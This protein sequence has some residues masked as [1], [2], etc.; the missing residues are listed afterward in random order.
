LALSAA[1]F[2]GGA[3]PPVVNG[4]LAQAVGSLQFLIA[5]RIDGTR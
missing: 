3:A 4:L 2:A 1:I 5:A